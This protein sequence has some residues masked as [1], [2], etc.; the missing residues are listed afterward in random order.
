MPDN[1][2]SL[3]HYLGSPE[4]YPH[5]TTKI[6]AIETHISWVFLTGPYA[7]KIKKAVTLPFL[8][9]STLE[10]REYFCHEELRL[11]RRLAPEL[12]LDVVPIGGNASQPRIGAAPALEYAVKMV[13]FAPEETAE[14]LLRTDSLAE[15][16]LTEL[17]E[18]IATFHLSLPQATADTAA[19][20]VLL[21]LAE[22]ESVVRDDQRL[23]IDTIAE[24]LR[25]ETG[26][27]SATLSERTSQGA[28]R[29]CHGDLH[30]GNIARINR[31]L[32]AFDCL[33]FDR[34]LR[35][36]DVVDE[37]AF[38]HMDLLAH[39]HS[40]FAFAFTNRYLELTGDYTGLRLLRFY[41]AHR[42]LIRAKVAAISQATEPP[43]TA[44]GWTR[45]YLDTARAQ[46]ESA[47]PPLLIMSGLS[48][49]G[50]TT[51]ARGLVARLGA[52]QVRSDVERKRL[53]G[54]AP[55][56][57]SAAGVGQGIYRATASAATYRQLAGA[58]EAA[59]AGGIPVIIDA[60]FI[61]RSRREEFCSLAEKQAAPFL[62]L[63]CQASEQT[64]RQRIRARNRQL[65]DPSDANEAVL[66][67]QLESAD[68]L[69]EREM[70]NALIV[71]AESP[72]NLEQ[73]AAE[74]AARTQLSLSS[75][76][77]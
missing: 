54:M 77:Y 36:I 51:V 71:N 56:E 59:L 42:A 30:L 76:S 22:L 74:I 65:S 41:A 26:R 67:H 23:R 66:A 60:T 70:A 50:K 9:F 28:V 52:V 64:L 72:V 75:T 6:R 35:T 5:E 19:D 48:G 40:D 1:Q 63:Y 2:A 15:A 14:Q 58:A 39:G 37:V 57:R 43:V 33:E 25:A 10:L 3:V 21:N 4:A 62:I 20:R 55:T 38:L 34:S 46:L 53:Q 31:Q 12:Y 8:D 24:R 68:P 18:R 13:Q 17:A 11:N 49:S 61:S 32:I 16:E 45:R 69:S 27:Q 47:R 44:Q 29:E 73:L 7:Y